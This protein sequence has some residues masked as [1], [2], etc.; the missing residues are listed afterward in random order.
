MKDVSI[1]I[2]NYQTADMVLECVRS[3]NEK[4]TGFSYEIIIVDNASGDDSAAKL[5]ASANETVTIIEAE[6]NLG[7][8]R[9]NNLGAE[10]ASGKY[11]L[12]LNPDTYLLNNAIKILIDYMNTHP[13]VGVAG[14]CLYFPD[15]SP[16]PSYCL[17]FDSI[18]SERKL[19]SWHGILSKKITDKLGRHE[20]RSQV[21]RFNDF[22][23]AIS[24]AYVF[25][26][27]MMIRR[28]VFDEVNGFDPDFFMYAEEEELSWRIK[29]KGHISV[30]VPQAQIVHLEG[31][32][33]GSNGQ[34]N[35]RQLCMRMNGKLI[36]FHKCFGE[37]GL[38][39]FYKLRH[40]YY[41]RLLKIEKLR[42]KVPEKST[43]YKICQCLEEEY[44]RYK[45]NLKQE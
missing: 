32:S 39:Q 41:Q 22:R 11:L 40:R 26:A 23:S 35:R 15:G 7:F 33:T 45:R 25:G 18:Q 37:E 24:V 34:F 43:V 20:K 44:K 8:G 9:G 38:D 5:K 12:L 27:D 10:Y 42:H 30:C 21:T 1:I 13:E 17:E 6:E 3:I 2:V 19:A 36:Y 31:A 28:S 16:A 4:S 14:G 29:N